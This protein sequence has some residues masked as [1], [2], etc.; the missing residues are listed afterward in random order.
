MYIEKDILMHYGVKRRSGRYPWG[1]GE[2]PYQHSGDF[3]SR[4]ESL[5]KQGL[6]DAEIAKMIDKNM[7]STDLR[8]YMAIARE[9]RR[10]LEVARAKSL[11]EDGLNNSEIAREMG[12]NES[13]IRSYFNAESERRMNQAKKTADFLKEQIESKGMID[14]GA[15]VERE[16]GISKE[17]LN[18]ALAILEAEGYPVYGIGVPQ[19]TNPNRQTN[20][21]VI[22]KPGTT[23]S[24]VYNNSSE[25]KS[26]KEYYSK[27][28]GQTFETF[29]YPESLSSKR[30][31]VK[32]SEDGGIDKDG[33]IE[34]RRGV[35]DISLGGSRYAQVR[36]L[37]DGNKYM[38]G[39]AVYS[40]N[41][42]DGVD[43][44]FNTNKSKSTPKAE[45]F[46]D[47]KNDPDNPFGSYIKAD[48]QRWYT[49]SNG[50]EKL[51]VIN[52]VREEGDWESWSKNLS[53]QM[54]SKQ[55]LSLIKRQLNLT[56]SDKATEFDDIMSLTNPT[57]KRKLLID[58][59]DDCDAAAVHLKA[60]ALPRQKNQVIL[61][62]T[63]LKSTE[64]Y[65]PNFKQGEQVALIRHPHGGTF[66]IP[67]LK[68]NN[69]HREAKS[70]LGN[71]LDAVGINSKVAERLSGAD[72][73]GDTVLVIPVNSKVKI[74]STEP[75]KGLIGFDPKTAYPYRQG[76]K[77]MNNTQT[78]MGKISNLIT[79]MTLKGATTSELARAVR[80]SMVVIDAEK[81]K[82][83]YKKSYE[84]NGI[85]ELKKKY[86]GHINSNG[87]YSEGAST[88]IS[89]A[90]S[91]VDVPKR[92][93]SPR[94]DPNTG[95]KVYKLANETYIDSKGNL[96]LRTQKSTN[97]AE[98]K[99]ANTLS[100][101]TS[102]EKLYADYANKVKSL[103]NTARKASLN[104]GRLT[105][106]KS[107]RETY[108][109]EYDS[110]MAK[111]NVAEKNAPRERQAQ[112]MANSVAKA[113]KQSNPDMDKDTYNKIKQQ[114]LTKARASVG[115]SGKDTRISITPKE[116]E[117][118]QAGAISDTTLS[119]ILVKADMKEVR[120]LATPRTVYTLT[121]AKIAKINSMNASGY[122]IS[123]IA[124]ALGVSTSTVSKQL[125]N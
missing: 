75:L 109:K 64:I 114:E 51:S 117:A 20:T 73:D 50:K 115:A 43:V 110:L 118:I 98:T 32:Y 10:S 36:I 53:S 57:V 47:I 116:W 102:V 96:K 79:D 72:F 6:S 1:S 28:G 76:M 59:A 87:K 61:P 27:D 29:H 103:A 21:K 39:M 106:S 123:E 81:H 92:K 8:A 23:H 18:Q 104:T 95:E 67:I 78:E 49:D 56:Y 40:D 31:Q 65:A 41:M 105:M 55:P 38:K 121:P 48:G 5:K 11:R 80:H 33:V 70:L 120:E 2:N 90:S 97:M 13:T 85:A 63:S 60:A 9:E 93:G 101:G 77:V 26:V 14:V 68:V 112:L 62:V 107:A 24:D 34:L 74:K 113:K 4:V 35:E 125:K 37:V 58:F 108:R 88:L 22:C 122:S 89:K 44:I 16:L 84:D 17:K 66:E 42:P 82:L 52:K 119:R 71:A 12:K 54:L 69:K 25:I 30:I 91:S 3:L 19:V 15:G 100:S 94:I 124:D 45:V 46:K 86:Q 111:L 99:D 83:D 7:T